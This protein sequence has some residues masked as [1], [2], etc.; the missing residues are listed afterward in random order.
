[1]TIRAKL[2][3]SKIAQSNWNKNQREITFSAQ[4]DQSIPEDQR[5]FSATPSATFTMQVDNPVVIEEFAL[6]KAF[7]IDFVAVEKPA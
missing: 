4:Y 5:F 6:D 2:V 3:V 1:M 7:Y